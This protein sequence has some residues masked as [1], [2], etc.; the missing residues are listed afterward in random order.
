MI[1]LCPNTCQEADRLTRVLVAALEE[2]PLAISLSE[3]SGEEER[4][5][6]VNRAFTRVTGYAP[7]DAVGR[8]LRLLDG[9]RTDPARRAGIRAA[10]EARRAGS[11]E[12]WSHRR[13]G[14][15]FLNR[16]DLAPVP[17]PV[18]G[19]AMLGLHTDITRFRQ[20]ALETR[21][22]EKLEALGRM[23]GGFAHEVNNLLQPV[24]T[25]AELLRDGAASLSEEE[26]EWLGLLLDSARAASE[27]SR[28]TLLAARAAPRPVPEREELAPVVRRAVAMARGRLPPGLRVALRMPR[29]FAHRARV[30]V[31][32][33]AQVLSNLLGNAADALGG[34]GRVE[35]SLEAAGEGHTVLTVRDGGP[36]MD[37]ATRA[38]ALEPFF[39][40]KPLGQ[41]TG[42]GLA[43]VW[44]LVQGWGGDIAIDST[45][46]AGTAI[47]I[48]IP[49]EE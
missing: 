16:L 19:T 39:T 4:L 7:D 17:D 1:A 22:R 15:P 27:L 10:M 48:R 29:G 12:V 24:L 3:G 46:G 25:F 34:A 32:E 40:T 13:D 44:A 47:R 36:G 38:R 43:A 30:P 28:R 49:A 41:G 23:A 26:R 14:T 37:E 2:C 45:P 31:A 6:F 20:E 18:G 9:P 11:F 42:L 8:P 5:I 21:Q 35:V 33:M